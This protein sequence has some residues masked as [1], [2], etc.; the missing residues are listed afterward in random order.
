MANDIR[1][2]YEVAFEPDKLRLQELIK[3]AKG[4]NRTMAQ[5][6][7]ACGVS[8]S[9][10][11][12]IANGKINSAISEDLLRALFEHQDPEAEISIEAWMRANG[13][14][15]KTDRMRADAR[16][17][18]MNERR[19]REVRMNH[20]IINSLMDRGIM[21]QRMPRGF[22]RD[23]RQLGFPMQRSG[24]LS[25]YMPEGDYYWNL[26]IY[27]MRIDEDSPRMQSKAGE[28]RFLL[29]HIIETASTIFLRD[30]WLPETMEKEKTTFVFPDED[31][32]AAF[33]DSLKYA[34]VHGQFSVILMDR[35]GER[36]LKEVDLGGV[37]V[38]DSLFQREVVVEDTDDWRR[39]EYGQMTLFDVIDD[40]GEGDE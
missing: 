7:E 5:Y 36:I 18:R 16:Y 8:A 12:R 27:A 17:E 29:R 19:D 28:I 26:F 25:L 35:E 1:E 31:I 9:T 40:D 20:V 32:F 22:D 30:A 2:E 33:L 24:D 38:K 13:M 4:A 6:A 11:S 21:L 37:E 10:L 3:K 23:N 15:R 39:D 34:K 14:R